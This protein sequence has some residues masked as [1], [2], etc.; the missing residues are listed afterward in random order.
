VGLGDVPHGKK[1][2]RRRG[3]W[4]VFQDESGLSQSP[5][6]RWWWA[7]RGETPTLIHN[8]NWKK[9]SVSAALAYRW[10]NSLR[11]GRLYFET[12]AG[13]YNDEKLIGFLKHLKSRL[14]AKATLIWDGL[15]AHR[16]R[17]M[18]EYV[19][20]QASWLRV[21][22]LPGYAPDLNPVE[23]LWG[24]V[25]GQEVANLCADGLGEAAAALSSGLRR[26]R[27]RPELMYSFLA[28]AGLSF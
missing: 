26:V 8:F 18:T 21:E 20:S 4:V 16:S 6:V 9:L 15:P 28:H 3:A 25:K 7:P 12:I 17:V 5:P 23:M 10:D 24:N 1:N 19:T 13:S 22:R 11:L 27:R 2:A 14:R